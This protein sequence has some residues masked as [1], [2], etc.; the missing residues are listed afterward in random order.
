MY[1]TVELFLRFLES[2]FG[3]MVDR[4][5]PGWTVAFVLG[6]FAGLIALKILTSRSAQKGW[7]RALDEKERT[8]QRIAT[9]EREWRVAQFRRDGWTDEQIER[10]ILQAPHDT[11]EQS[12][13]HWESP[14]GER[15]A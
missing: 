5:G 3:E 12:R 11:P 14:R 2:S 10:W 6:L 13:K 8:I 1:D 9:Q 7:E 15:K 4:L